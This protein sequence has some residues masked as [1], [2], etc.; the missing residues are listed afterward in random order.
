MLPFYFIV[1]DGQRAQL[2]PLF[3][4]LNAERTHKSQLHPDRTRTSIKVLAAQK[5]LISAAVRL[6]GADRVW[7]VLCGDG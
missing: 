3:L 7:V 2:P 5:G 4:L 1:D 6:V